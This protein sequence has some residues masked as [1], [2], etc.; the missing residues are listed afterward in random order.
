M[1]CGRRLAQRVRRLPRRLAGPARLL[2]A[3]GFKLAR[4]MVNFVMELVDMP[5]PSARPT[6]VIEPMTAADA[7]G[8]L[9]LAPKEFRVRDAAELERH[10]LHNPYFPPDSVQVLRNRTDGDPIGVSILVD[11]PAY[12]DPHQIDALAPCFRLGAVGTEGMQTKRVNGLFSFAADG[13]P[14]SHPYRPRFARPS[15]AAAP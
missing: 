2:P 4:E 1:R 5:T 9:A 10:L 7:P 8:V 6:I 15:H 3:H 12:A 13:Q 14:F 11:N